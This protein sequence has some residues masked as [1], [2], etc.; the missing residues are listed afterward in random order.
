VPKPFLRK[1]NR[2]ILSLAS[3]GVLVML[4]LMAIDSPLSL[5][6]TVTADWQTP[7]IE[8]LGLDSV[9]MYNGT[10]IIIDTFTPIHDTTLTVN[11]NTYIGSVI[12]VLNIS[13]AFASDIS[14][15]LAFLDF[16]FWNRINMNITD[17][18]DV[19]TVFGYF[20]MASYSLIGGSYYSV[21][22]TLDTNYK[23]KYRGNYDISIDWSIIQVI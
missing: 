17:P 21:T 11:T 1:R 4:V 5:S 16:G 23:F 22:Y 2:A 14:D 12:V 19:K 13:I 8:H 6:T 3:F 18:F 15:S 7:S 20:D 9:A 10:G